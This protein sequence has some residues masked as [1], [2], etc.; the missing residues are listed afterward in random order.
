MVTDV[1]SV[2]WCKMYG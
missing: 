1:A 2:S